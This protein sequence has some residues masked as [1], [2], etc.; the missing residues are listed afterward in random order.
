MTSFGDAERERQARFRDTSPT[1]S[2]QGRFPTDNGGQ[3][4]DYMLALDHE[5]ETLCPRL[6]SKDGARKF[7]AERRIKWWFQK[8]Y[9]TAGS[10]GPTRNMASSQIMCINFLL[11]LASIP[12]ALAAAVRAIDDDVAG[13][14]DIHH[15]GRVSPVE[16]E[17]IGVPNS[18]E[19]TT[20]RGQYT[21]SV[22]AFVIA[23][24]GAGRRAYL[25]EWKYVEAESRKDYGADSASGKADTRRRIYSPLY[26][27]ANSSFNG[28]VPMNLMLYGNFYQLMRNRLLADRMVE[29]QELGVT[30]AK[31]VVVV[32]E[33]NSSY[34]EGSVP[35]ALSERCCGARTV[36][37]VM[38]AT[39]KDPDR[40]FA[41]VS[42]SLLLKSVE[43]E[44]GASVQDWSAYMRERYGM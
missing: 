15:E 18:L 42:P 11:P 2:E 32:Q 41:S 40:T 24:T 29:E 6:R 37:E 7:L 22:D 39:L 8:N 23:D 16:F 14:V 1:I 34:R 35:S 30:D 10:N 26:S 27:A 21:T 43:R 12:G 4:H 9:D 36:E 19:G 5:D 25:M 17:W 3:R 28:K 33:G 13:V 44:C 38:R 31:L 20:T